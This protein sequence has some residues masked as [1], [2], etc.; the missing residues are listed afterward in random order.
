MPGNPLVRFDEGGVGRTAR[1]HPLSY[2]TAFARNIEK[3]DASI[4]AWNDCQLA[5]HEYQSLAKALRRKG[6]T[7]RHSGTC[8]VH[9]HLKP[10]QPLPP[11]RARILR[12]AGLA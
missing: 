8:T 4:A 10:L 5:D 3:A 1:C 2:S 12:T 11:L 6:K 9:P 7:E